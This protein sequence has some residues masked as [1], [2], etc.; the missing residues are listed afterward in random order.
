[1]KTIL[2]QTE[3]MLI[4]L[5]STLVLHHLFLSRFLIGQS[6]I[7]TSI[8]ILT[9]QVVSEYRLKKSPRHGTSVNN[10]SK[11]SLI[12]RM[13]SKKRILRKRI[14]LTTVT[15]YLYHFKPPLNRWGLT[16]SLRPRFVLIIW[17]TPNMLKIVLHVVI[18]IMWK[19]TI[20]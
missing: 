9:M 13:K 2:G 5:I 20:V 8:L 7:T 6:V 19:S 14:M 16:L 11:N 15:V 3:T 1:M 4:I 10:W 12:L 18:V 17:M